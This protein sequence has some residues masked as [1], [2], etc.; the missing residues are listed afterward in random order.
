ME[1]LP[2]KLITIRNFEKK[3]RDQ[4]SKFI[5]DEFN[6]KAV[7]EEYLK[8][9]E[10]SYNDDFDE[11]GEKHFA[12]ESN[13]ELIGE[14]T[15]LFEKPYIYFSYSL[16]AQFD[17]RIYIQELFVL[18]IKYLHLIYPHRQI[19]TTTNKFNLVARAV[20]EN[21]GFTRQSIDKIANTYTYSIFVPNPNKGK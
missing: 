6:N 20:I 2:G 14:L 4:I 9:V 19:V 15:L 12:I 7:F 17:T 8:L 5:S 11:E 13:G 3:D 18:V 10:A 21:L 16:N 1:L